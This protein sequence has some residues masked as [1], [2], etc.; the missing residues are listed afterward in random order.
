MANV[1][2]VREGALCGVSLGRTV[3]GVVGVGDYFMRLRAAL[4]CLWASPIPVS[5]AGL[6]GVLLACGR[7][8]SAHC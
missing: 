8:I 5:L 6:P 1:T 2:V 3:E 4:R 7:P